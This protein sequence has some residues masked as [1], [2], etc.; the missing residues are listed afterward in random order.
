M[1]AYLV[2]CSSRPRA[3][4]SLDVNYHTKEGEK[5][6]AMGGGVRHGGGHAKPV[7]PCGAEEAVW[8]G[9]MCNYVVWRR[10]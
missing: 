1:A 8:D 5:D 10:Q 6:G 4:S 3:S 9:R 7:Q 2:A